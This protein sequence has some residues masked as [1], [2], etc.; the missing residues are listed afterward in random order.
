MRMRAGED[1]RAVS[2]LAG[3]TKKTGGKVW[4][5]L[6]Q[7]VSF[8]S[9]QRRATLPVVLPFLLLSEEWEWVNG[10]LRRGKEEEDGEDKASTCLLAR[11]REEMRGSAL[12]LLCPHG[13][14]PVWMPKFLIKRYYSV[15]VVI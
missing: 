15:F 5:Y 1:K 14:G 11:F 8:S 10:V 9:V 2:Q 7:S 12:L 3:S 4:Y 13:L 6:Q